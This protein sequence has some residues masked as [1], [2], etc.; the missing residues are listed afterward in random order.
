MASQDQYLDEYQQRTRECLRL[1]EESRDD[2]E[3]KAWRELALCWLLS[4]YG[5]EFRRGSKA[6]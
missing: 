4:D 1:A 2:Q 3:K 6:A 5:Q